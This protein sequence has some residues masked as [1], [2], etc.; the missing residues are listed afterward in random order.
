MA[1]DARAAACEKLNCIIYSIFALFIK[2]HLPGFSFGLFDSPL[3]RSLSRY[4]VLPFDRRFIGAMALASKSNTFYIFIL[5]SSNLMALVN[6]ALCAITVSFAFGS[7]SRWLV[8]LLL[9]CA[10][11]SLSPATPWVLYWQN[12]PSASAYFAFDILRGNRIMRIP[13][14]VSLMPSHRTG[15]PLLFIIARTCYRQLFLSE[16]KIHMVPPGWWVWP[17]H[18]ESLATHR[19]WSW[20]GGR[21][22]CFGCVRVYWNESVL[23]GSR[24]KPCGLR[25]MMKQ[26]KDLFAYEIS[27]QWEKLECPRPCPFDSMPSDA[28]LLC[29]ISMSMVSMGC[30]GWSRC[31]VR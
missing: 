15:E 19:R 28:W 16:F 7:F 20:N 24:T 23:D 9:R 8:G 27:Y 1:A 6:Y 11:S 22:S 4:F 31:V 18:T 10:L 5:K 3:S 30:E 12:A 2:K 26:V 13:D 29:K 14:P 25:M 21:V 17:K